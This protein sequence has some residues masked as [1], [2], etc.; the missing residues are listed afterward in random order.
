MLTAGVRQGWDDRVGMG[1]ETRRHEP[2]KRRLLLR[3]A[4]A[5]V[6]SLSGGALGRRPIQERERRPPTRSL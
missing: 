6:R 3:L 1:S 4:E 5:S 2:A